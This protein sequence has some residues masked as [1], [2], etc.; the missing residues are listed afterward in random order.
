MSVGPAARSWFVSKY[1]KSENKVYASKYYLPEESWPKKHVWWVQI[2]PHAIDPSLHD[3]VNILCQ[4]APG[5]DDFHYLK[6]PVAFILKHREKFH[7]IGENID[8]YLSAEQHNLFEE[9][10]GIGKLDFSPFITQK[11]KHT[12]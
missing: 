2:P 1:G 4:V 8:F 5:A 10:R 12:P 3:Y 9:I 11:S 7:R 6:V